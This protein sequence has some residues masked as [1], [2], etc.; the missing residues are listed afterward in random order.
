M[1]LNVS[2]KL[3]QGHLLDGDMVPGEMIGIRIDQTLTQDATGTLVMLELEAM[4]LRR[5]RTEVSVQYVDHNLIQADF[6]NPDD[7]LFLQSA[8]RRFGIWFSRP[9]NGVSH[10]VHMQRF[11]KPGK[12][13]LG[14]DSHTPAAGSMGML[15]IGAGGLDVAMAMA[16]HPFY[17]TMPKIWG[18]RLTGRFPEWVGAKDVILEMLRRHDVDGG[19]GYIIE[20]Y[21]P[22]LKELSAMDRHV[23]ANMGTELGATSTV[24]PSDAEV[25][26]FLREQDR[27]EDWS[28]LVPD[29]G[30]E[31][32]RDEEINLSGL[33]PLIA[34]PS[35]PGNVVPV[36]E[37]AGRE[38]YQSYIGSSANPGYRDFAIAA[39]MVK[40]RHVAD[41]VSFDINP[42]SRQLLEEL[43]ESGELSHLIHAGARLHQAGCNGC[44]GMGQ[45]PAS[46]KISLRTVPR[47]F[48]GRSGT[49]EDLVYLCSPETA[50]ASAL[51][52]VITDPRTLEMSY[53]KVKISRKRIIN[54]EMLIPPLSE[55]EAQQVQI[56][57]GPNIQALPPL[58]ALP[59]NLELPILLKVGDNISTDEIMP[60]GARVLP[61]RSNIPKMSEYVFEFIDP[62][63]DKRALK[64]TQ[65]GGHTIIAGENY[66]QGSSREHAALAPRYLG[67]RVV[68]AK[69]FARIHRM[70]LVNFGILPV[71]FEDPSLYDRLEVGDVITLD[72]LREQ[73]A[74]SVETRRLTARVPQK[75][76]AFTVSHV[77]FPRMIDVVLSGGLTNWTRDQK[78]SI[79]PV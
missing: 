26:K 10:P 75:D 70:N 34:K 13:L 35:S 4:E 30:A 2:Q 69:S 17:L 52:G 68:I 15:A 59:D 36:R 18:V 29:P 6:R 58:D 46:G 43:I 24:F 51:T 40:D 50:T 1:A 14:S 56:V 64:H 67:L 74:A 11:G 16:G 65:S 5:V 77:L 25:R 48:P 33:E 66:G 53:P 62:D 42:T 20:Y 49:K 39:Q 76:L 79:Q 61:Y 32:D 31:Y 60:A 71:A 19:V 22:G 63:Y 23:I 55:E 37:L 3:I 9:G 8:C 72:N 38:I 21:G 45:A 54:L 41:N 28:E 47:N 12:T 57:K 73:L 7:H 27:A 44:I 78:S